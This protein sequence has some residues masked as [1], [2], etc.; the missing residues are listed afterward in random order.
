MKIGVVGCGALGSY[1]GSKLLEIGEE[2]SIVVM[3]TSEADEARDEKEWKELGL[4]EFFK[5]YSEEDSVY[6]KM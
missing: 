4:R 5:G 1:Y 3:P 6:D 2:V